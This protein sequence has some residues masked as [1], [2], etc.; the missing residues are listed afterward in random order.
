MLKIINDEL[1]TGIDLTV[2][3]EFE[4]TRLVKTLAHLGYKRV[5]KIE[6]S[7]EFSV[8]GDTLDICFCVPFGYRIYF[9]GDNVEQ[10]KSVNIDNFVTKKSE[11]NLHIPPHNDRVNFT[12]K[13]TKICVLNT[14]FDV[15]IVLNS[16]PK[17]PVFVQKSGVFV[18]ILVLKRETFDHNMVT[19]FRH[20]TKIGALVWHEK[21]GIGKFV[22]A[23]KM[24]LGGGAQS[25]IVLQYHR[26]AVVYVP[27]SQAFLL[28][29]YHGGVR[30]LDKI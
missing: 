16:V 19:H 11:R 27:L 12:V 3:A 7:G 5:E 29:N 9:L 28:Y 4:F 10:I 21:Y 25:Y 8:R 20:D 23:K 26:K 1:C 17:H 24:N 30:R 13:R 6:N 14:E 2:G 22:G 15:E 18:P